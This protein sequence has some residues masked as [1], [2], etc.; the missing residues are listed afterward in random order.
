MRE[1][2]N[3]AGHSHAVYGID[4]YA[5]SH[6]SLHGPIEERENWLVSVALALRTRLRLVISL[7][8]IKFAVR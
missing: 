4:L 6:V 3:L 7:P 5:T 2:G 1:A 8:P